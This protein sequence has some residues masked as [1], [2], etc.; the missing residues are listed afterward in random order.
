MYSEIRN[1]DT[2][3]LAIVR[4][5]YNEHILPDTNSLLLLTLIWVVLNHSS[6]V[7]KQRDPILVL[8]SSS[9]N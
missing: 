9:M 1:R 8:T 3:V 4:R 6:S 5:D 2:L 7:N